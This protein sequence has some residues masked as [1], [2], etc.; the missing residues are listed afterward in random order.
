MLSI[1]VSSLKNIQPTVL[2][3]YSV[4]DSRKDKILKLGKK[5]AE[6]NG[7]PSIFLHIFPKLDGQSA[8]FFVYQQDRMFR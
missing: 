4:Q 5:I 2:E 6:N 3:L 7:I 1:S 8:P